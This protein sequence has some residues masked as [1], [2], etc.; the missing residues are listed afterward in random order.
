MMVITYDAELQL[1]QSRQINTETIFMQDF[2]P[3]S[4]TSHFNMFKKYFK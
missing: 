1:I 3:K 4:A 2:P